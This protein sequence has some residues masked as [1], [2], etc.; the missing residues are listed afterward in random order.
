MDARTTFDQFLDAVVR[1]D[2]DAARALTVEDAW[3]AHGDTARRLFHGI[4]H[5]GLQ[6]NQGGPPRELRD[7][8][9]VPVRLAGPG[10]PEQEL[11][12]LLREG[13]LGWRV[14]GT[15]ASWAVAGL[16]LH[17]RIDRPAPFLALPEAEAAARWAAGWV[18][19]EAVEVTGAAGA[20]ALATLAELREG[21]AVTVGRTAALPGSGRVGVSLSFAHA[22]GG[23]Q[24]VWAVLEEAPETGLLR[25]VGRSWVGSLGALL[26]G[27][28]PQWPVDASAGASR[29]YTEAE[30]RAILEQAVAESLAERGQAGGDGLG[31]RMA[32]VLVDLFTGALE[33][34]AAD[35]ADELVDL[36]VERRR[37]GQEPRTPTSTEA[38]L[39]EGLRDAFTG[40]MASKAVGPDLS[41][42]DLTLDSRFVREHGA[43]LVGAVLGAF[44]GALLPKDLSLGVAGAAPAEG[45]AEAGVKVKLDL[46]DLMRGLFTPPEPKG[47]G[48]Q[49]SG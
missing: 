48:S 42:E 16:Y 13:V 37:R 45:E 4:T 14:D 44:A 21:A 7:R 40:F 47:G 22:D 41:A 23:G 6:A 15:A 12:V 32:S 2:E 3:D 34:P 5:E 8:A 28:D 39:Q 10:G 1:A 33:Q 30:A 17:G 25:L 19:G 18:A 11:W 46:N 49:G 31:G 35:G 43:D 26:V 38:R 27:V 36:E 24:Q 20:D 9:V 29:R